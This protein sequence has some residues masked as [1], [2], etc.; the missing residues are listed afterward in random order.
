ML[1]FD[2][3]RVTCGYIDVRLLL[4]L[5]LLVYSF[6]N[7][8]SIVKHTKYEVDHKR[9]IATTRRK[10]TFQISKSIDNTMFHFKMYEEALRQKQ[11]QTAAYPLMYWSTE[12]RPRFSR[13]AISRP[14]LTRSSRFFSSVNSC[15]TNT[16]ACIRVGGAFNSSIHSVASCVV[17][18]RRRNNESEHRRETIAAQAVLSERALL[19]F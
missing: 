8:Y 6:H 2:D 5:G 10:S 13:C 15:A 17:G 12:R 14:M 3:R 16:S 7:T 4:S 19:L 11:L 9:D 18:R 1:P